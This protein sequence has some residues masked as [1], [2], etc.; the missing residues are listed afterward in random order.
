MNREFLMGLGEWDELMRLSWQCE[1]WVLWDG[2]I[3]G[4]TDQLP[5]GDGGSGMRCGCVLEENRR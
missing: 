4:L 3:G 1:R 2:E 5:M